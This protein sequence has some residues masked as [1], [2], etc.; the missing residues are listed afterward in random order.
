MHIQPCPAK[1]EAAS[2]DRTSTSTTHLE[3]QRERLVFRE[4]PPGI[5]DRAQIPLERAF[6]FLKLARRF[7]ASA[8]EMDDMAQGSDRL[9]PL[10]TL[11]NDG[12]ATLELAGLQH[13]PGRV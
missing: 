1:E 11:A 2:G 6:C 10:L 13:A 9:S 8:N 12:E 7:C 5:S 4:R 3:S